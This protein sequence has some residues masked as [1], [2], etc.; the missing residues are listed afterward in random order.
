MREARHFIDGLSVQDGPALPSL[1]GATGAAICYQGRIQLLGQTPLLDQAK[2]LVDWL[3]RSVGQTPIFKAFIKPSI[4][5]TFFR[6]PPMDEVVQ[7]TQ[8]H[9]VTDCSRDIWIFRLELEDLIF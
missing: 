9:T 2:S 1:C 6:L 8:K 5:V 3:K 7:A 4:W